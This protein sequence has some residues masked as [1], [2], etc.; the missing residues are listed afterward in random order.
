MSSSSRRPVPTAEAVDAATSEEAA[1]ASRLD[2]ALATEVGAAA[3]DLDVA[4]TDARS[5]L[6]WLPI[7]LAAAAAIAGVGAVIGIAQRLREFR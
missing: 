1:A 5:S 2:A 3:T 7:L 6:R 4:I